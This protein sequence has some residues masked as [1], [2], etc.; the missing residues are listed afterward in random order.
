MLRLDV[1]GFIVPH[2]VHIIDFIRL[3]A[4]EIEMVVGFGELA[5]DRARVLETR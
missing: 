3:I 4:V 2:L 1:L 5:L